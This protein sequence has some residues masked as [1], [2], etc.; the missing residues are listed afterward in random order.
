MIVVDKTYLKPIPSYSK[1]LNQLII[2]LFAKNSES[3]KLFL[4][5][6]STL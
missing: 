2:L 6:T 4:S 3:L 1:S 5:A